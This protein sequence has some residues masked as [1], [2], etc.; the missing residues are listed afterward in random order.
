MAIPS[1]GGG[2]GFGGSGGG[3]RAITPMPAYGG[4]PAVPA[5]GATASTAI[6]AN[7][8][9]LNSILNLG[10]RVND[11]S[12][13]AA[14]DQ[15]RIGLPNYDSLVA[16]S[17]SNIL[18]ELQGDVPQ[19][20]V[21]E[22]LQAAAERG[23]F[24]GTVGSENSN[25][26]MLRALGLTSLDLMQRGEQNLS[27]AIGRTPRGPIFDPSRM[28]ITPGDQQ[29]A[30]MAAN[31]YASAPIPRAAG[32]RGYGAASSGLRAGLNSVGPTWGNRTPYNSSLGAPSWEQFREQ[33]DRWAMDT[34]NPG[35]FYGTGPFEEPRDVSL[36][37]WYSG[38]F[39]RPPGGGGF[40]PMNYDSERYLPDPAGGGFID[41]DTGD[42]YT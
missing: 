10:G 9:N 35:V 14:I 30:E 6:G 5:P 4:I 20:V 33:R 42:Y 13:R 7:A 40:D 31:L 19:D 21:N 15:L 29:D 2:L 25:A 16:E 24:T 22:I 36:S 3:A 12:N 27:A 39:G 37:D 11:Y 32:T 18:S 28:F 23:I 17:S 38:T 34:P 1:F 8:G 41:L 26:A